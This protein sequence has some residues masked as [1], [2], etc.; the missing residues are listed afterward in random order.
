[1]EE[2]TISTL[3][4]QYLSGTI[5]PHDRSYLEQLMISDPSVAEIVRE[6]EAAYK[7]LLHERNRRLKEKLRRLDKDETHRQGFLSTRMGILAILL[8]GCITGIL[9]GSRY[10]SNASIALRNFDPTVSRDLESSYPDD[11]RATWTKAKDAFMAK[12]FTTAIQLYESLSTQEVSSNTYTARWN[13]LMAQ[14][15][16]EGPTSNWKMALE[17]FAQKAPEP[18]ASKAH[19]LSGVVGSVYYR[20]FHHRLEEDFS[21]L[22]PRLI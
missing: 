10:W 4:D 2:H 11:A 22:K 7:V 20:M 16:L 1:M 3:I 13:I 21:S 18:L 15:A 14:L 6:S 12:D 5:S 9:L 17:S 8:V 19:K